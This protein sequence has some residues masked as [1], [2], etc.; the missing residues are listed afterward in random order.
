[1]MKEISYSSWFLPQ[2]HKLSE[3]YETAGM[4]NVGKISSFNKTQQH[5]D[6][7]SKSATFSAFNFGNVFGLD[8][9]YTFKITED[10]DIIFLLY[11]AHK[12]YLQIFGIFFFKKK[13]T[14][15]KTSMMLVYERE[16]Q[17]LTYL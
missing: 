1:M 10:Y 6:K 4:L 13:C 14:L 3:C 16:N 7:G 11:T 9:G 5:L 15:K 2:L 12:T 8:K 17:L